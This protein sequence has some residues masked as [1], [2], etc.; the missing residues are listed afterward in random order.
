[1]KTNKSLEHIFPNGI[2]GTLTSRDLICRQCNSGFG[3]EIDKELVNQLNHIAN[4]LN[5]D[6]D[7]GVPQNIKPEHIDGNTDYL[8]APGGKPVLSKPKIEQKKEGQEIKI[9]ISARSISEAREILKGLKKKYPKI[10]V[11]EVLKQA[12]SKQEYL[13]DYLRFNFSIGGIKTFSAVA[14]IAYN[15]LK[16]K[17]PNISFNSSNIVKYIK[18]ELTDKDLVWFY[19][20]DGEFIDKQPS[21]VLHSIVITGKRNSHLYAY[22]ELFNAYKFVVLLSDNYI[23]DD[24]VES[25]CFDVINRNAVTKRLV[26]NIPL[27]EI[28]DIFQQ[29]PRC[30]NS[31]KN[32][33]EKLLSTIS[34][35]QANEHNSELIE[36]AMKKSIMKYP[37]GTVITEQM[38]NELV[39]EL[40]NEITPLLVRQ[41]KEKNNKHK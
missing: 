32:E 16:Y 7:R 13:K 5:I 40:V 3:M 20:K 33:Y 24:F 19:Y 31:L 37:E 30:D 38:I 1:M 8:L 36:R 29:K 6:R 21:E 15:Y 11:E 4:M 41:F 14:K 12:E 39:S 18:G 34:I 27:K 22:V 2:G 26:I 28:K 10:D 25:Y 35:K 9:S 23:G 17:Y